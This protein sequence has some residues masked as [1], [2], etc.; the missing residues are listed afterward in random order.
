MEISKPTFTA[1][2]IVLNIE[3][4]RWGKEKKDLRVA[5]CRIEKYLQPQE[6][7]HQHVFLRVA[8]PETTVDVVSQLTILFRPDNL[9]WVEPSNNTIIWQ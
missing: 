6:Y 9:S 8:M 5:Y 7:Q 1:Q 3:L 4:E 2:E